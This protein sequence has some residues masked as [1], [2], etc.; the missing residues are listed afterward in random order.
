VFF[1]HAKASL[2]GDCGGWSL[3]INNLGPF[4]RDAEVVLWKATA[5]R[6]LSE[7]NARLGPEEQIGVT[8][9]T[10][11]GWVEDKKV[12][13]LNCSPAAVVAWIERVFEQNR[14]KA[15]RS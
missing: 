7:L 15:V 9:S 3:T 8:F 12:F 1:I 2:Q 10:T 6:L 14:E 13:F 11:K 4:R 5:K